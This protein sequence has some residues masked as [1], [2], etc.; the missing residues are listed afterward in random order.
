MPIITLITDYGTRDHYV[1]ALKGVILG[2]APDVRIVDVTHDVE[3]YNV[4]HA[5]FVLRQIW[6][7]Y[8]KG[9]VHLAVVD[10]GV[11]S[12]RRIVLGRYDG[13][14]V[15]AP[16]NGL[17]TL[18]HRDWP[19]EAL[20][21]VENRRFFLPEPSASFHGRDIMAPVAAHLANGV[22]P[23]ELGP[24]TDRLEMLPIS[25][26][27]EATTEGLRGCVLHVD[28]FGTLVTNILQEQLVERGGSSRALE[29]LVNGKSIGPVRSTFSAAC[30]G[31][32]IALVGSCGLLEI[33]VNQ[34]RAV[35]LF[36]PP[37]TIRIDVC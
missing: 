6:P 34:G 26:R 10:P 28:H 8:P 22:H 32:P 25:N 20:H 35:E 14:C 18:V 1:G 12:E 30:L 5:A 23:R 27:A 31:E 9:T 17:V 15:V 3:P 13:R 7:W 19:A 16:D 21:L 24:M 4:L 36:G 29:V 2:L 11:G 37:D 33:A